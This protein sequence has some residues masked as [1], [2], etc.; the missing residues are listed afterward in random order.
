MHLIKRNYLEDFLIR[1]IKAGDEASLACIIRSCLEEFNTVKQGT[2]Y[3]DD[4]TNHLFDVFQ[5]ER[6][7][8]FVVEIGAIVVGGAGIYPTDA[9]PQDTCELVKMYLLPKARGKGI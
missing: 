4:T 8:Y 5:G 3:D 9:L 6:S 2:V 7:S 1:K